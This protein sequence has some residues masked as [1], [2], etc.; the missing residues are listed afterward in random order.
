MPA[1]NRVDAARV[2]QL[3]EQG[4]TVKQIALRLGCNRCSVQ[5]IAKQ[6]R[7]AKPC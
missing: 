7:E 3:L 2:R 4:C 1:V 6:M 5:V